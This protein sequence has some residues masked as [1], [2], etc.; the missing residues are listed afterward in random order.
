M[1]RHTGRRSS[2]STPPA[3]ARS[4]SRS[5]APP[6]KKRSAT[7]TSG[8][9]PDRACCPQSPQTTRPQAAGKHP[10]PG[11]ARPSGRLHGDSNPSGRVSG[12]PSPVASP[13]RT[14]P[15]HATRPRLHYDSALTTIAACCP[16]KLPGELAF[17]L[18]L[19]PAAS[20]V[21]GDDVLEHGAQGGRVDGLALADGHGAGG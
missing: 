14:K 2:S 13:L 8:Y 17:A 1:P 5:A 3:A 7:P 10:G 9:G 12:H 4:I 20:S 18:Q 19:A 6:A 15:L 16:V 21:V 11:R